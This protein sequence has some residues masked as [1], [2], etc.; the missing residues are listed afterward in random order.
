MLSYGWRPA[1]SAAAA[2]EMAAVLGAGAAP[3]FAISG[4]EEVREISVI[5]SSSANNVEA[6]CPRGKDVIGGGGGAGLGSAAPELQRDP[7]AVAA[8]QRVEQPAG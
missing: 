8:V 1:A 3:A 7:H 4:I 5:D 2:L 6:K